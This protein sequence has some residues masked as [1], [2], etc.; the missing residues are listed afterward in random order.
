[1][2]RPSQQF[3]VNDSQ[4]FQTL[5]IS[6]IFIYINQIFQIDVQVLHNCK[7]CWVLIKIFFYMN[8]K[9]A[10]C[11]HD[12][13]L[14]GSIKKLNFDQIIRFSSYIFTKLTIVFIVEDR[15]S[16]S[17]SMKVQWEIIKKYHYFLS[18]HNTNFCFE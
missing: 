8:I 16:N 3:I 10:T 5:G 14:F 9:F 18:S 2:N 15:F 6:N 4:N 7:L 11:T 17:I 12:C 1:M 13:S